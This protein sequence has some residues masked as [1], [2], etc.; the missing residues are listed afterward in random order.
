VKIGTVGALASKKRVFV[1]FLG[2]FLSKK[3]FF[4]DGLN[5][6]TDFL[7]GNAGRSNAKSAKTLR[8]EVFLSH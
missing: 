8:R 2:R 4:N 6:F 3:A 5:G 7:R 1:D